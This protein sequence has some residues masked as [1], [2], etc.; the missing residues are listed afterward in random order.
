MSVES[1]LGSIV[2]PIHRGPKEAGDRIE[3]L[4]DQ[5]SLPCI[6]THGLEFAVS[7][8]VE[9][10]EAQRLPITTAIGNAELTVLP[11]LLFACKPVWCLDVGIKDQ[12]TDLSDARHDPEPFDFRIATTEGLC[13]SQGHPLMVECF[14]EKLK[15][16]SELTTNRRLSQ[17]VEILLSM[18]HAE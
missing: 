2:C 12:R 16:S 14:V 9:S 4:C 5:R 1:G 11:K 13:L 18:F 10:L 3:F 8:F 15:A 6:V 7:V 17:L